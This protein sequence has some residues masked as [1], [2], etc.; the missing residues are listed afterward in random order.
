MDGG[1]RDGRVGSEVRGRG[2]K[3]QDEAKNREAQTKGRKMVGGEREA[4]PG[5]EAEGWRLEGDRGVAGCGLLL[6]A[7]GRVFSR[8]VAGQVEHAETIDGAR[9]RATPGSSGRQ[10]RLQ[11]SKSYVR[12]C[13]SLLG[14]WRG[15]ERGDGSAQRCCRM[16]GAGEISRL[17][18]E[19]E[20]LRWTTSY[21]GGLWC[22]RIILV[23]PSPTH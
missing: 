4:G 21:D 12:L 17:G 19:V 2:V 6:R 14:R 8:W 5:A 15:Q 16:V 9:G 11:N 7:G 23:V 10:M 3:S 22:W 18:W 13:L 1:G 20:S